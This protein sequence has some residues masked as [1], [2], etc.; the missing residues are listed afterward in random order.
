[1]V[2]FLKHN[3]TSAE[4]KKT[5]AKLLSHDLIPDKFKKHDY[6]PSR[7]DLKA[8]DK[9]YERYERVLT[10]PDAAPLMRKN[11]RG[12]PP[13]HMI[14]AEHDPLRDDGSMYV[15]RCEDAGVEVTW[16]HYENGVHGMFSLFQ[17]DLV[18][19]A[20]VQSVQDFI[21]YSREKLK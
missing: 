3:Y 14:T 10:D 16:K 18:L 15:R 5:F 4:A 11:L 9:L 6:Q 19:E 7:T 1:M 8:N 2:P 20:G 17:G 13:V 12:L 21:D